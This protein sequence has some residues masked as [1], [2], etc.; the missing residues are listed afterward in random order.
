MTDLRRAA[1][2]ALEFCEI[3]STLDGKHPFMKRTAMVTDA[4][5][6]CEELRKALKQ[7]EW[8]NLEIDEIEELSEKVKHF[9][10]RPMYPFPM[11]AFAGAFATAIENK[12]K[13]KNCDRF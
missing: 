11:D 1:E 2:A 9:V 6:V 4:K 8:V 13:E 3:I 10:K 5:K 12:V 7:P